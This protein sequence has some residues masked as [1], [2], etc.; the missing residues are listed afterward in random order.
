[1]ERRAWRERSLSYAEN[2]S[3]VAFNYKGA[4]EPNSTIEHVS[5][6]NNILQNDSPSHIIKYGHYDK[7]NLLFKLI[8]SDVLH[9][10]QNLALFGTA[11]HSRCE[12]GLVASSCPSVRPHVRRSVHPSF[13]PDTHTLF[14]C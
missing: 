11:Q 7:K 9:F 10:I 5:I 4:A 14:Q 12:M 6:S 3:N 2:Y 1:M 13:L 8:R